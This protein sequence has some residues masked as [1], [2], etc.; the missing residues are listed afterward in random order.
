MLLGDERAMGGCEG[1]HVRGGAEGVA[2]IAE[3]YGPTRG[4]ATQH[5]DL[6]YGEAATAHGDH[7]TQSGFACAVAELR[8]PIAPTRRGPAD[9]QSVRLEAERL[10][11]LAHCARARQSSGVR[12]H[13]V[14]ARGVRAW[15]GV[16][17]HVDLG[18][19]EVAGVSQD[20]DVIGVL[21]VGAVAFGGLSAVEVVA[22]AG[23]VK[24]G[25]GQG[26]SHDC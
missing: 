22:T 3:V 21:V 17:R 25:C 19:V 2:L 18:G 14:R 13:R 9:D 12:Q 5:L 8:Q 10:G 7:G 26:R 11:A 6:A 4:V 23:E 20:A 15:G 1:H 24:Q 16:G